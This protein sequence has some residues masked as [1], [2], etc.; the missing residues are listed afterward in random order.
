MKEQKFF[1]LCA[2]HLSGTIEA[3]EEQKLTL[4]LN[5]NPDRQKIFQ[6]LKKQWEFSGNLRLSYQT[7]PQLAWE[8]FSDLKSDHEP[9]AVRWVHF[10]YRLVAMMV[11]TVGLGFLLREFGK[12]EPYR[13]ATFE[14]ETKWVVLPDSSRVR[15][16]ESTMLTVEADFNEEERKVSLTGE[17][18]FEIAREVSK[19]FII[20][21]DEART[22]ALGTSFNIQALAEESKIEIYVESGKVAFS[23]KDKEL[24]LT[25]GMAADFDK[26]T[27]QLQLIMVDSIYSNQ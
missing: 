3:D 21:T 9:K 27:N 10:A 4:Y 18:F 16:N 19:P 11:L 8:K 12:T 13:Y 25:K 7:N 15:M 24:I 1:G 20:Q 14:G 17:A 23:A 22:R 26:K 6:S 2:K 5:A